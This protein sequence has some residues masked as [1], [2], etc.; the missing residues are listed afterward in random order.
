MDGD[1]RHGVDELLIDGVVSMVGLGF[2]DELLAHNVLDELGGDAIR[3]VGRTDE[4]GVDPS[5][6]DKNNTRRTRHP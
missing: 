3:D 5:E 1:E 6:R 4:D 2:R